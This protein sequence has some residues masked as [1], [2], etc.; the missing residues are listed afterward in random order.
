[1]RIIKQYA[2]NRKFYD[3]HESRYVRLDDILDIAKRDPTVE[4][5]NQAGADITSKVL[6]HA[7]AR[8]TGTKPIPASAV[9]EFARGNT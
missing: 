7:V 1:M 4:V 6:L 8:A 5:R 3:A 2:I 9:L